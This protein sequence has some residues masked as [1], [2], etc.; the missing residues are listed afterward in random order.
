MPAPDKYDL[1]YDYILDKTNF[2]KPLFF[3]YLGFLKKDYI[4]IDSKR[5]LLDQL[6]VKK[7][8]Y[9]YDDTHWSPVA[10]KIIANEIDK[11]VN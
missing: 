7:D 4:Y 9:F 6:E 10:S 11:V 8:M 5:K 1:Y 2:P 3:Q